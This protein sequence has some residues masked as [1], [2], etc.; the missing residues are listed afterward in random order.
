MSKY[1]VS[2]FKFSD[3]GELY[4][5]DSIDTNDPR[6]AITEWMKAS[7]TYRSTTRIVA[8]DIKYARELLDWCISNENTFKMLYDTYGSPYK[9]DYLLDAIRNNKLDSFYTGTEFGDTVYPFD[10]G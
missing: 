7:A 10:F 4:Y 1:N 3:L 6:E 5:M 9:Q 8:R 2:W